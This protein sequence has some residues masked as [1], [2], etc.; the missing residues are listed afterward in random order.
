[1]VRDVYTI[2]NST[3]NIWKHREFISNPHGNVFT[4]C[5]ANI[6]KRKNRSTLFHCNANGL[7]ISIAFCKRA[8]N[9]QLEFQ[10]WR[11]PTRIQLP[12]IMASIQNRFYSQSDCWFQIYSFIMKW[13]VTW[14][15]TWW[16][17]FQSATIPQF[18]VD[19]NIWNLTE[20]EE[21]IRHSSIDIK[22][23][24]LSHW[25]NISQWYTIHPFGPFPAS[26]DMI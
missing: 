25:F 22:S 11:M 16:L 17:C 10:F 13:H 24:A 9:F 1:M 12:S 7:R 23:C 21:H 3:K 8:R 14:A 6:W 5:E 19:W 20:E 2:S 18:R 4:I 15:V 26:A